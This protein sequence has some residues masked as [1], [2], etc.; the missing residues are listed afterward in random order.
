VSQTIGK[1]SAI[2]GALKL[3]EKTQPMLEYVG[4][5]VRQ[6]VKSVC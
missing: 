6:S 1:I 5:K 2:I 3:V 4:Y